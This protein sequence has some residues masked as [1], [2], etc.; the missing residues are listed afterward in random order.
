MK[1]FAVYFKVISRTLS[2]NSSFAKLQ[3]FSTS[4][5]TETRDDAPNFSRDVDSK[6]VVFSCLPHL[7][8]TLL[9]HSS[10]SLFSLTLLTVNTGMKCKLLWLVLTT[11]A[12]KVNP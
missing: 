11:R 10:H 3:A 7:G 1:K 6:K 8:L 12:V 5:V 2:P 4:G 9:T